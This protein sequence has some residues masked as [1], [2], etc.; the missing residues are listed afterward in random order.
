MK[1]LLLLLLLGIG[2]AMATPV[3]INTADAPT[4]AAALPGIGEK[5]A[6]AI[7]KYRQE[8]G[9]F[10]TPE[11]LVKVSGIGEKTVEK[12]KV[13]VLVNVPETAPAVNG[14]TATATLPPPAKGK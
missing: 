6:E 8:Q 1:K 9:P 12:I 7:V 5:K 10:K 4:I 2:N 14:T 13:D 3:N 11:E